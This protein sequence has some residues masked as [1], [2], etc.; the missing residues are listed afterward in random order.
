MLAGRGERGVQMAVAA[1]VLAGLLL[2]PACGAGTPQGAPAAERDPTAGAPVDS[3]A[4]TDAP[5][6]D[7]ASAAAAPAASSPAVSASA[8][9]SL[10]ASLSPRPIAPILTSDMVRE[11]VRAHYAGLGTCYQQGLERDPKLAGTVAV[12]L[13]V[14]GQGR[15]VDASAPE[16]SK[17]SKPPRRRRWHKRRRGRHPLPPEPRITDA[18]VV[19]CL[20]DKMRALQF[21]PSKR[22][23]TNL[24]YPLVFATQ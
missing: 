4:A 8:S 22:G 14:D 5:A 18:E 9:A 10:S 20:L 17:K 21:P 24:V 23:L 7:L 16:A 1:G 15:V 6:G 12:H 11:V 19:G 13:T 2:V 3:G